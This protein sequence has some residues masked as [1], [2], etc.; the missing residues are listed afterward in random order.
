MTACRTSSRPVTI[1][2]GTE[3]VCL[4][5]AGASKAAQLVFGLG[6]LSPSFSCF[7]AFCCDSMERR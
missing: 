4:C 3:R 7:Q 5:E 6:F 1:W 2:R